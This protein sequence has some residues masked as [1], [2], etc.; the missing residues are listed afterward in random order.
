MIKR[1]L[2]LATV[3][4]LGCASSNPGLDLLGA[5]QIRTVTTGSGSPGGGEVTRGLA[6]RYVDDPILVGDIVGG[7]PDEA[8]PLLLDAYRAEGLTPDGMDAESG[9]VSV[10]RAEWSEERNGLPVSTFLD[11]GLS[12]TGRPLADDAAIV[13]AVAAQVRGEG[14]GVSRV[15]VRLDAQAF[16][17]TNLGGRAQ[18]CTTTGV[19]ERAIIGHIQSALAPEP[20]EVGEEGEGVGPQPAYS[21]AALSNPVFRVDLSGLPFEPGDQI[22]VWL[23]SSERISGTFLG[24][25]ADTLL[26]R[27]TRRTTVPL[28]AIQGL[29]VKEV[30]RVPVLVGAAI[31]I[32]AGVTLAM[33]TDLGIGGKHAI[34]GEI[35]NPGLGAVFGGLVG[36]G[37]GY[38]FG[39]SWLDVPLAGL[40][41]GAPE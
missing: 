16:P 28:T 13:L 2:V 37:V 12:S 29:Q 35:L 7:G 10:S 14:D 23:S 31:G 20:M 27:K 32:A 17:K 40:W 3:P 15:T 19:L 38:L 26:L 33:T 9:I 34:Q 24:F 25:Q 5:P 22:R 21:S 18:D 36:A 41:P 39:R 4:L 8:L 6:I 1:L 11:C 30:R